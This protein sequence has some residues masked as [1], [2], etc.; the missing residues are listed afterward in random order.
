MSEQNGEYENDEIGYFNS[1][2]MQMVEDIKK[3]LADFEK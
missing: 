2:P 1:N 3:F